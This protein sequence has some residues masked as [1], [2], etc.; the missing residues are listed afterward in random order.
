MFFQHSLAAPTTVKAKPKYE[1]EAL[2]LR[3]QVQ[4]YHGDNGIFT[5]QELQAELEKASRR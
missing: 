2:Q 3:I 1:Q 4:K 5:A